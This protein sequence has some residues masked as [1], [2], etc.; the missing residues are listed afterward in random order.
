[1]RVLRSSGKKECDGAT[2][3]ALTAS[4]FPVLPLDYKPPR[5]TMRVTFFYDEAPTPVGK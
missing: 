1:V 2:E 3:K 5:V 4:R